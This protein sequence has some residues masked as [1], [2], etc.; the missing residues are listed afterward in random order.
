MTYSL[1]LKF[2]FS[3]PK[4]MSKRNMTERMK[5]NVWKSTKIDD[6]QT[7]EDDEPTI[8]WIKYPIGK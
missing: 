8:K 5:M 3:K 1:S 6:R 7:C 2:I 4:D